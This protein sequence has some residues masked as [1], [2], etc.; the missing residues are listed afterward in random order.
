MSSLISI[1]ADYSEL[2][3]IQGSYVIK[4]ANSCPA[5]FSYSVDIREDSTGSHSV[6]VILE[7][8]DDFARGDFISFGYAH[9]RRGKVNFY[10]KL[11]TSSN[12]D[13]HKDNDTDEDTGGGFSPGTYPG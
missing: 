11:A 3:L 10:V 7:A 13:E 4:T 2:H 9:G 1:G 5:R 8:G 12:R 6:T